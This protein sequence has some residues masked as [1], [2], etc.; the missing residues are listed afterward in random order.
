MWDELV[1][2]LA[3]LESEGIPFRED[4]WAV[5]PAGSYG[6]YELTGAETVVDG[7][8][9]LIQQSISGTVDLFSTSPD[10]AEAGRVQAAL[11]GV[12]CCAFELV[13]VQYERETGYKHW[14]WEWS[15]PDHRL[16][17]VD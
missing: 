5:A 7:D 12:E 16:L 2:A 17:E 3:A 14:T 6:V 13:S 4:G 9:Q 8:D 11:K 15:L 10:F 1:A